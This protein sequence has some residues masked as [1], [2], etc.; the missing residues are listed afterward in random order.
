MLFSELLQC[1]C[2]DI[3]FPS[4]VNMVCSL[5]S[6]KV[7]ILQKEIKRPV[8]SLNAR[9]EFQMKCITRTSKQLIFVEVWFYLIFVTLVRVS[10]L[11]RRTKFL[12][13]TEEHKKHWPFVDW[14]SSSYWTLPKGTEWSSFW[15]IKTL[16][17]IGLKN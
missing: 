4:F 6:A 12:S 7:K 3:E 5:K 9:A 14:S 1:M 8:S 17:K 11:S 15:K 16:R 13:E 10:Q 2:Y